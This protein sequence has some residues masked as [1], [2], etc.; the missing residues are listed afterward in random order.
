MNKNI[1]YINDSLFHFYR[2]YFASYGMLIE[3][4]QRH[5]MEAALQARLYSMISSLSYDNSFFMTSV[6][7]IVKRKDLL[8][9]HSDSRGN[10]IASRF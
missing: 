3:N 6:N 2:Y 4:N 7:A 5:S 10:G 1:K 9:S 8:S